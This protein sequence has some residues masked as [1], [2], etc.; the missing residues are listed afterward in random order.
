MVNPSSFGPALFPYSQ[1]AV[2][3][4]FVFVAGQVALDDDNNVVAPG[5]AYEQ[6]K[7]TLGRISRVLA[8][9]GGTLSDI[10]TAT[11]FVPGL[12]HLPK[13]NKAWEEVFGAHRPA[14]ATVVAGLLIDGLVVEVQSTAVHRGA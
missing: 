6:T 7:V 5:D 12:E 13:F 8:E 2:A 10:V 4:G 9:V 11:V 1:A 14:R 3:N